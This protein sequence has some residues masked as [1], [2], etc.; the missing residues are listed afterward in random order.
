MLKSLK[1]KGVGPVPNLEANFGERLNVLTGDNGLGKSF[2]LDVIFWTQ[3]GSW[4]NDRVALPYS[5]TKVED[6]EIEYGRF[7][8]QQPYFNE[9]HFD[10]ASQSWPEKEPLNHDLVFYVAVDGGIHFWDELRGFRPKSKHSAWIDHPADPYQ[11]NPEN[12]SNGLQVDGQRISNGIVQ[13]WVTWFL[14][15]SINNGNAAFSRLE[16]VVRTLSHPNEPVT[17][18]EPKRIFIDDSRDFP[19]LSTQYGD[20]P[21]PHWAAGLRRIIHFAYLLVWGW[22]EHVQNAKL[23][24]KAPYKNIVLLIDEIEAHLHPKWQRTILPAILAVAKEL[25]PEIKVQFFVTTHSPLVLVSLEPHFS[26]EKD[27]LFW[28]DLDKDVIHFQEY[29]WSIHGDATGWLTSE[30]FGLKQARSQ[31]AETAI[32]A[33]KAFMRGDFSKLPSGMK[34]KEEIHKELLRLLPGMDPFW[35]RWIVEVKP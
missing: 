12:L 18:S 34:T 27:K 15:R 32:D 17:C 5:K 30:I 35:P 13:D 33:A 22:H 19:I 4:P 10:Y 1:L 7:G 14:Q 11:F 28:F 2:L 21:Y 8:A 23:Q 3:T 24:N 16:S 6:P 26:N 31:E 20:V 9:F 25:D 29:P